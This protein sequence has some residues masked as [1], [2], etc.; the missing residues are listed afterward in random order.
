[1]YTISWLEHTIMHVLAC[2]STR[3]FTT[4][5]YHFTLHRTQDVNMHGSAGKRVLPLLRRNHTCLFT[6]VCVC[7]CVC[8]RVCACVCV[9]ALSLK[10]PLRAVAYSKTMNLWFFLCTQTSD[11]KGTLRPLLRMVKFTCTSQLHIAL[12]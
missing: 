5:V 1:M 4:H 3:D 12:E 6:R 2:K 11:I 10:T 7:V 8:V 9:C